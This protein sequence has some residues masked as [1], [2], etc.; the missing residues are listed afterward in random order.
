MKNKLF[1]K[2]TVVVLFSFLTISLISTEVAQAQ[3]CSSC[4]NI[5][6]S[7]T[8]MDLSCPCTT[9]TCGMNQCSGPIEFSFTLDSSATCCIDSIK[10]HPSSGVC[11]EGCIA[12]LDPN[13]PYAPRFW[14]DGLNDHFA[15]NPGNGYYY[16]AA[17]PPT[18]YLCPGGTL[19]CEFC[20]VG[21]MVS[22]FTFT[23]YWTDGTSC[24]VTL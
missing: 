20:A 24:S 7:T 11:W 14:T 16:G 10:V 13:P 21:G 2:A 5:H 22:G 23:F 6:F 4:T 17:G 12:S 3:P 18:T 15:C 1:S 19:Y 8:G 9:E